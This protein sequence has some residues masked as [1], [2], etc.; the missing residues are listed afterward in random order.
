MNI[1][2]RLA[3]LERR[4]AELESREAGSQS[5]A[6][7]DMRW[8][9][10]NLSARLTDPGAVMVVGDVLLPDGRRAHWQE[11]EATNDALGGDWAEAA[12]TVTAL[13][14]PV[15][16][17]ILQRVLSGATSVSELV[18]VEGVGTSGQVYHHLRRLVAAGW[19]RA[20]EGGQFEVPLARV[21]PL[22]TIVLGGRR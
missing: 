14:H 6:E 17:R 9:L 19:L 10:R 15:R 22:L 13:G 8:P 5:A 1:A 12:E 20:L 2:D 18:D 16:L 3:A 7:G 4:V 21:V 11:G